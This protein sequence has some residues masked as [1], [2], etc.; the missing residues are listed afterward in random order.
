MPTN[1]SGFPYK[2]FSVLNTEIAKLKGEV[3]LVNR[4]CIRLGVEKAPWLESAG[5]SVLALRHIEDDTV[6]V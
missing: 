5:A 6:G 1:A 4:R 2:E 3:R